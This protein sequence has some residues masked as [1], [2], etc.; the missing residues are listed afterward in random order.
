MTKVEDP[1][2]KHTD[3][4]NQHTSLVAKEPPFLHRL[5]EQGQ[6]KENHAVIELLNQLKQMT[7]KILL[8][9]VVKEVPTYTKAIKEAC[10]KQ[11]GRKRKDPKT[12][13]FLG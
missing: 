7:I 13:H 8:L 6:S 4:S 9:D 2:I 3:E 1:P 11:P 5:I 10:N 12:I